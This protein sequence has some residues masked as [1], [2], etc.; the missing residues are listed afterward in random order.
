MKSRIRLRAPDLPLIDLTHEIPAFTPEAAG[1]WLYCCLPQFPRGTEH[2]AV[3]DPGVGSARAIVVLNAAG[4][5]LIAPDN[6]LLG[7]IAQS[8]SDAIAHRVDS[9]A[10]ARLGLRLE[11]ATFHGRDV[12]GPLAA[13]IACGRVRA[14][15]VGPPHRLLPGGL[16]PARLGPDGVLIGQVAVIDHYGNALTTISAAALGER[17]RVQ[18]VPGGPAL[19]FVQ[20]YEEAAPQECVALINSAGM[21]ELAA[22]R[23]SAAAALNVVAGRQVYVMRA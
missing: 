8:S 17:R 7:L 18:L 22:Y 23:S 1:Y 21:L 6:G 9:A 4:Q 5:T 20:T 2:L 10:L 16:A 14:E 19:R 15:A 12:M 11:S 3:V 13:E